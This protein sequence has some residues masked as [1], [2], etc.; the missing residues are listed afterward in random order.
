MATVSNA[1]GGPSRVATWVEQEQ[2]SLKGKGKGRA[3][4]ALSVIDEET[5]LV[6]PLGAKALAAITGAVTT[7]LLSE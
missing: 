5:A 4:E 2:S 1:A 7:S 6:A 3:Y